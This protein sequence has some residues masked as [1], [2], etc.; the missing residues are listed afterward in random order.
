MGGW[1]KKGSRLANQLGEKETIRAKGFDDKLN[2]HSIPIADDVIHPR[3]WS[4][5]FYVHIPSQY[6]YLFK[7]TKNQSVKATL[8]SIK[9]KL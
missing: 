2:V 6:G 9:I 8:K 3:S 1:N 4:V 5:A 7:I